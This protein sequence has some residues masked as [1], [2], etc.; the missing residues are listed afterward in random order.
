MTQ[1]IKEFTTV[2]RQLDKNNKAAAPTIRPNLT[3]A[4]YIGPTYEQRE[5]IQK[6]ALEKQ[7]LKKSAG[8]TKVK[9]MLKLLRETDDSIEL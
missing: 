4:P 5:E 1:A 2:T 9:V 3:Q 7:R 8:K 6:V